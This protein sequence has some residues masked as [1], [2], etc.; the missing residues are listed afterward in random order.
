MSVTVVVIGSIKGHWTPLQS[1]RRDRS[2]PPR[3]SSARENWHQMQ[4]RAAVGF[5]VKVLTFWISFAGIAS[6]WETNP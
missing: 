1:Q 4:S 5:R 3:S 2:M 6:I